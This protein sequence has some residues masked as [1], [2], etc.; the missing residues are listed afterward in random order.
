MIGG[1]RTG[2]PAGPQVAFFVAAHVPERS[3]MLV[4]QQSAPKT[5]VLAL[6]MAS[7]GDD[8]ADA[9]RDEPETD[10]Q[11]PTM[12]IWSVRVGIPSPEPARNACLRPDLKLACRGS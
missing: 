3:L 8:Q 4:P 10:D 1:Q 6:A 5:G 2:D 11:V 9:L 7:S 12:I